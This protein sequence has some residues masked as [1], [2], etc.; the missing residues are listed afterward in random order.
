VYQPALCY[1]L[2]LLPDKSIETCKVKLLRMLHWA[3]AVC[4][5]TNFEIAVLQSCHLC[6]TCQLYRCRCIPEQQRLL[7]AAAFC[8]GNMLQFC[9]AC[10]AVLECKQYMQHMCW[11]PKMPSPGIGP[12]WSLPAVLCWCQSRSAGR[13]SCCHQRC[14]SPARRWSRTRLRSL[15]HAEQ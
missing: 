9:T 11:H 2:F 3:E 13:G 15:Q 7:A 14:R 8:L 4:E 12:C 10:A 6:N 5:V 1:S